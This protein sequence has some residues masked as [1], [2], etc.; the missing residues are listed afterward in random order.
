MK[1]WMFY[2]LSEGRELE[3]SSSVRTLKRPGTAWGAPVS[4]SPF[5]LLL[6]P[7]VTSRRSNSFSRSSRLST[8]YNVWIKIM[9]VKFFKRDCLSRCIWLLMTC[10]VSSW[11]SP[12]NDPLN[13]CIR[14]LSGLTWTKCGE[15]NQVEQIPPNF[16][17][18]A[19]M[20]DM[21]CIFN[22]HVQYNVNYTINIMNPETFLLHIMRQFTFK[23]L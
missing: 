10:M 8:F 2:C 16:F 17:M 13:S 11:Y 15:N 1:P 22:M 3:V 5:P 9:A 7:H 18:H 19:Q 6:A 23:A 4:L 12:F 21:H 20:H 14:S